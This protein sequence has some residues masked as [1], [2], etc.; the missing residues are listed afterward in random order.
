MSISYLDQ[1]TQSAKNFFKLVSNFSKTAK[2]W[3]AVVSYDVKP[4]ERFDPTLISRRVYNTSD[5]FLVVMACVGISSFDEPI[6]Q[7]T[8]LL[9]TK[10]MVERFKRQTGFE[11][12]ASN[13]VNGRARWDR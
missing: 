6:E 1:N 10:T 4:D 2:A 3:D 9:P 11:S 8:I 5:E 12:V 13:R 7:R